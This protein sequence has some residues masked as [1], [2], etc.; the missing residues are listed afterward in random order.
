MLHQGVR[1]ADVA[2][3]RRMARDVPEG[4][5]IAGAAVVLASRGVEAEAVLSRLPESVEPRWIGRVEGMIYVLPGEEFGGD[6][7]E[8]RHPEQAALDVE[9]VERPGGDGPKLAGNKGEDGSVDLEM[10]IGGAAGDR[11][12]QKLDQLRPFRQIAALP[13]GGRVRLPP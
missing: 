5:L 10:D 2:Q 6:G 8:G 4:D 13:E 1:E 3:R 11:R 9:F 12:V 7:G